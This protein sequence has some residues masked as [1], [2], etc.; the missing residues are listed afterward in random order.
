MYTIYV[1]YVQAYNGTM[2]ALNRGEKLQFELDFEL[3]KEMEE[4]ER[5]NELFKSNNTN[6]SS[7][8]NSSNSNL[9]KH[10]YISNVNGCNSCQFSMI[11]SQ[12]HILPPPDQ[13]FSHSIVVGGPYLPTNRIKHECHSHV[14]NN[15]NITNN[16]INNNIRSSKSK[17][18]KGHC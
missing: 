10:Q 2:D 14:I 8:I 9:I 3:N 16:H 7:P 11:F 6:I 13:L 1:G 5:N 12:P 18:N 15:D 17:T 4:R